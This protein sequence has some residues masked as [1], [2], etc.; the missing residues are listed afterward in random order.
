MEILDYFS[1][2]STIKTGAGSQSSKDSFPSHHI[3]KFKNDQVSKIGT[4]NLSHQT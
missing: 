3:G 1:L 4:I 2:R